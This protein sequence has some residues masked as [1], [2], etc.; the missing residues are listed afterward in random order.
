MYDC[1]N[2]KNQKLETT[3]LFLFLANQ[4]GLIP[5][6]TFYAR[7]YFLSFREL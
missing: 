7:A 2:H 6:E 4:P 3:G 5:K 1:Q